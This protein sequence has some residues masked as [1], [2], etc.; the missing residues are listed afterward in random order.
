MGLRIQWFVLLF[1]V[2]SLSL[3]SGCAA[4]P[5]FQT[6][7]EF[8]GANFWQGNVFLRGDV[9]V[10]AGETLTIA[11]GTRVQF[12]PPDRGEDS[13][14]DHPFFPGSELIVYGRVVAEGTPENPIIF[15]AADSQGP[16]G[17][18]GA[19]NFQEDSSGSFR[20]CVL[21]QAD[22]AIHSQN[23]SLRIEN[24][25]FS[26]NLVAIRF[27]Q[28]DILIRNNLIAD[29]QTGI[30]FHYGAPEIV[31][32]ILSNND[33]GIFVTSFPRDYRISGNTIIGSRRYHVVLGEEVPDDVHMM[34]NYWGAGKLE[35]IESGM[36][37]GRRVGYIG[38]VLF[39]PFLA[40][41]NP[42][43]GPTWSR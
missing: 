20:H 10:P 36:F 24:C 16:A 8:A 38:R 42:A 12:L 18:W 30:R 23:A 43:A 31:D 3:I 15:E 13:F 34:N 1:G 37:D 9:I 5:G 41:P 19:I 7:G 33:K 35:E 11:P 26:Q 25:F 17:F 6:S 14:T 27:N 22:S 4:T 40:S 39:E 32:N 21:T 2:A 28:T 29:N